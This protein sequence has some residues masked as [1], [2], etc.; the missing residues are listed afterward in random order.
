MKIPGDYWRTGEHA[1]YCKILLQKTL[2]FLIPLLPG[3]C[4]MVLVCIHSGGKCS[5]NRMLL[6]V[7]ITD[8]VISSSSVQNLSREKIVLFPFLERTILGQIFLSLRHGY[9]KREILLVGQ[10]LEKHHFV[11]QDYL[12]SQIFV[13][14]V[15]DNKGMINMMPKN[16]PVKVNLQAICHIIM[17]QVPTY[18]LAFSQR[19]SEL[20]LFYFVMFWFEFFFC[21][22]SFYS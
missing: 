5:Y 12:Y 2:F 14:I 6:N 16:S 18:T 13:T 20:F 3:Q 22:A 15:I 7:H 10:G 8:F 21:F 11:D 17:F 1:L 9:S 19:K 4:I